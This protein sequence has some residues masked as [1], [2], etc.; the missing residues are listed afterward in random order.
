[1]STTIDEATVAELHRKIDRLAAQVELLTEEALVQRERR[2]ERDELKDDLV[3]I[4]R[5]AY[6][7]AVEQLDE[8]EEYATIEDVGHLLKRVLRNTKNLEEM[9]DRFESAKELL[10]EVTPLSK[11]AMFTMMAALEDFEQRGY[12]GFV[13]SGMK[14]L[15]NVVENFTEEDVEALGDNVVLILQTV[16]EMTQPEVMTMLRDTAV[17]VRSEKPPENVTWR[18]LIREMR[19]PQVKQGLARF[20]VAMRSMS[21]DKAE[22]R[23]E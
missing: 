14:V 17:S 9:L 19:S 22:M 12:F 16:R 15:D 5:E 10:E 18:S 2:Q 13:R 1:M 8:V 3:P 21:G 11:S 6:M 20:M 7:Y 4:A 23:D